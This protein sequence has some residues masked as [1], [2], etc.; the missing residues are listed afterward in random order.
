[1]YNTSACKII[2]KV[3]F[4]LYHFLVRTIATFQPLPDGLIPE[5]IGEPFGLTNF[6]LPNT[7]Q[8]EVKY[9][10]RTKMSDAMI[11]CN[12][13]NY[14]TENVAK[15]NFKPHS[16]VSGSLNL[17]THFIL[18]STSARIGSEYNMLQ[19]V[20]LLVSKHLLK[21]AGTTKLVASIEKMTD[22][23]RT[24]T[25]NIVNVVES[26]K[27]FTRTLELLLP[28]A[29]Y[30]DGLTRCIFVESICQSLNGL[31]Q[32][33]SHMDGIQQI[34]RDCSE[35]CSKHTERLLK[36]KAEIDDRMDYKLYKDMEEAEKAERHLEKLLTK[37]T[38]KSDNEELPTDKLPAK[39]LLEKFQEKVNALKIPIEMKERATTDSLNEII[40]QIMISLQPMKNLLDNEITTDYETANDE[41]LQYDDL[42]RR[43][44][45]DVARAISPIK[46]ISKIKWVKTVKGL[47]ER[48]RSKKEEKESRQLN[49]EDKGTQ[50]E[51]QEESEN[52]EFEWRTYGDFY[53]DTYDNESALENEAFLERT[54]ENTDIYAKFDRFLNYLNKYDVSTIGKKLAENVSIIKD[55]EHGVENC[56]ETDEAT[57]G[58]DFTIPEDDLKIKPFH[59]I[60]ITELQFHC[61][62]SK[63]TSSYQYRSV[64]LLRVSMKCRFL[65]PVAEQKRRPL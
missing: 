55:Y 43:D 46:Q 59:L 41:A 24:L 32:F 12:C 49:V 29:E 36:V 38:E 45:Q 22:E 25:E 21:Q 13:S 1:M 30:M 14:N 48:K 17:K 15:K 23:C 42:E 50:T 6:S 27:K 40:N 2:C 58:E 60:F 63:V 9:N 64:S 28:E 53:D 39:E 20:G 56:P 65:R 7:T 10:F 47:F 3:R 61:L 44:V 19:S 57:N 34:M 51:E 5:R 26:S 31:E 4:F 11:N 54:Y 37:R 33:L 52:G 62:L 16:S 35:R 8:P 18:R